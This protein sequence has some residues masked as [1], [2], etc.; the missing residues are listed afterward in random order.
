VE[1]R[2][3]SGSDRNILPIGSLTPRKI[4]HVAFVAALLLLIT[5]PLV[6]FFAALT[7]SDAHRAEQFTLFYF[8]LWGAFAVWVVLD[9]PALLGLVGPRPDPFGPKALQVSAL[10]V[11]NLAV[12]FLFLIL[13]RGK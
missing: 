9:S 13:T 5:T 7:L 8:P 4:R 1:V 2:N 3:D 11:A 10:G 6:V 12:M